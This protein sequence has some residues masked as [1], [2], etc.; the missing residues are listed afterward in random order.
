VVF[1]GDRVYHAVS[2]CHDGERRVMFTLEY[3]TSREMGR[4]QRAFSNLK[5]GFAYFGVRSL[6]QSRPRAPRERGALATSR[7]GVARPGR[8]DSP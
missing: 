3:V 4:L 8:T 1:N 6:W 7:P 5:D 2:P